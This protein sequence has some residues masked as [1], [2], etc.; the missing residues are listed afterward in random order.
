[1]NS[2]AI[3]KL[4]TEAGV[5]TLW[6]RTNAYHGNLLLRFLGMLLFAALLLLPGMTRGLPRPDVIVG[7]T[8]HPLA[9][10]AG[11]RLAKRFGVPFVYEIRD[12]WPESLVDLGA[13][14]DGGLVARVLTALSRRLTA[15][16]ELVVSP[17]PF[18]DRHIRELGFERDFLWVP[19]GFPAPQRLSEPA[20]AA[21]GP[22]T[23]M[24]LG[25]HGQANGLEDILHAFEL[26]CEMRPD[27]DLALRFVGDGPRKA[28]LRELAQGSKH[29]ARVHFEARIPQEQVIAR[30]S[31]ADSLVV[32]LL[33]LPVYRFGVSLNKFAMYMAS[34][35]PTVVA[36]SA[37]NNPLEDA[38]AGICV[39]SG[40]P[41]AFAKA[42][43]QMATLPPTERHAMGR[44][45][46]NE[47]VTNYSYT[48]LAAKLATAFER[49]L[50]SPIGEDIGAQR[51]GQIPVTQ[52]SAKPRLAEPPRSCGPTLHC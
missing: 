35:R 31:C 39:E 52:D 19:N 48:A 15:Q 11:G 9:A 44:R 40:S 12:V 1:M 46:Y 23:F 18:A 32:T 27:L 36:S 8:V 49:L 21:S 37:P 41:A 51:H 7:S 16:A 6:I 14:R 22:F 34:G 20:Q 42:L 17:L 45:G 29:R 50:N 38:G 33:D 28:E 5:P 10:W 25:A 30:A 2:I 4:Q 26:A 3:R 24:Y 13:V 47:V 43:I